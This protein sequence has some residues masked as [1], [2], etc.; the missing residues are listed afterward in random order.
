MSPDVLPKEVTFSGGKSAAHFNATN[1]TDSARSCLAGLRFQRFPSEVDDANI[2]M[3]ELEKSLLPVSRPL[4]R[5]LF[6]SEAGGF[7]ACRILDTRS[8]ETPPRSTLIFEE[9]RA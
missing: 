9:I 2:R 6:A 8:G 3:S 1:G 4:Q 5:N 7:P